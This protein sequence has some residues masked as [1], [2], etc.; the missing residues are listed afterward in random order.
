MTGSRTQMLSWCSRRHWNAVSSQILRSSIAV[1]LLL[2]QRR[3]IMP[4]LYLTGSGT[5]S[6]WSS[7]CISCVRPRS[8]FRLPRTT[9][10]AAFNTRCSLL[11]TVFGAKGMN[12]CH[13]RPATECTSDVSMKTTKMVE[14]GLA[15]VDS[16]LLETEIGWDE[17]PSI[18]TC[19]RSNGRYQISNPRIPLTFLP[20]DAL[21]HSAV[22]RLLLSV[23]L[24]ICLSVRL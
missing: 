16:M 11:V 5:S 17:T 12:Q 13:S 4:S 22:L 15:D 1:G 7:V 23:R 19:W 2:R 24:S 21:V 3:V 9:R 14:A 20:R 6:Q 18:L 10:A 8:N